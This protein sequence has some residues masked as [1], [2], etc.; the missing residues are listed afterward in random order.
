MKKIIAFAGS[1]SKNSI[2]KQLAVYAVKQVNGA[3]VIVLDLNDFELPLYGI[4]YE[5]EHG[6]PE[7]AQKFLNEIK[8]SD[9][10]VLSLAEHNGAY[11]TV[12]KNIFDWMSRIDG[13]LWSNKPMLLLA[14][15]PGGRGGAT[16]L[17]I[18]KG[19]FPHMGGNII[20]DFSLPSFGQNFLDDTIVNSQLRSNLEE[21]IKKLE[22]AI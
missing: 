4:D 17:E 20:A 22:Q 21:A 15:S 3:E 10:I 6:I 7:N 8:S 11:A 9:G 2:N 13:K 12:F 18:A 14:T 1:N 16:V 5:T 19:R